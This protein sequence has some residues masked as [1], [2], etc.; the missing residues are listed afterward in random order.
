MDVSCPV[1]ERRLGEDTGFETN[2]LTICAAH[3]TTTTTTATTT[4]TTTVN[5]TAPAVTE[6]SSGSKDGDSITLAV[7]ICASLLVLVGGVLFIF[8]YLGP[9]YAHRAADRRIRARIAPAP[10]PQT[11][12]DADESMFVRETSAHGGRPHTSQSTQSFNI[13]ERNFDDY[14]T[15]LERMILPPPQIEQNA[16]H[17]HPLPPS[18][19]P[20]VA[21]SNPVLSLEAL[22]GYARSSPCPPPSGAGVQ[23]PFVWFARGILAAPQRWLASLPTSVAPAG[24]LSYSHRAIARTYLYVCAGSAVRAPSVPS[25]RVTAACPC[26]RMLKLAFWVRKSPSL[27]VRHDTRT[28]GGGWV[29]GGLNKPKYSSEWARNEKNQAD[30]RDCGLKSGDC[31]LKSGDEVIS[32]FNKEHFRICNIAV[33]TCLGGWCARCTCCFIS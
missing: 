29:G 24:S 33:F 25:P 14:P 6:A 15:P 16:E 21:A 10:S 30:V 4:I 20:A 2:G 17:G 22:E 5:T 13:V 1:P 12:D 32:K 28:K 26:H 3:L 23:F 11:A 31:G 19:M 7:V 18:D 27:R 9:K 8:M